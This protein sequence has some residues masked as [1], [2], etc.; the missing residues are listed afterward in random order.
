MSAAQHILT[1]LLRCYRALVSPLL[2]TVFRPLGFGCRFQPT[3][4]VYAIEAVRTHG[5]VRG[6]LLA[7]R[8]VCR[9][10][11]FGSSG[12]DPVPHP[13]KRSDLRRNHGANCFLTNQ[14]A[15]R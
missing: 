9:C 10:H 5:A 14:D 2:T 13:L 7:L 1:A 3:C 15:S 6:T 4:S 8:R 11:P 12:Y